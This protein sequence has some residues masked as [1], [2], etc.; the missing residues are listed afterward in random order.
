M[1]K[2][3]YTNALDYYNRAMI[4]SPYYPYLHI[5]MAL[6]KTQ[7]QHPVNEI[8]DHYKK[9]I[10]Y[11]PYYYGGYHY[12]GSW[13]WGQG[14]INE[15]I[16]NLRISI[17]KAP[18]VLYSRSVLM[19]LY[20]S[21][22]LWQE[23]N[24]LALETLSLFPEYAEAKS[25]LAH[26]E[27]QGVIKDE[28]YFINLGLNQYN[29][30]QYEAAISSWEEALKLNPRSAIIHNNIGSAF[31][32]MKEYGKAIPWLEKALEIDPGFIL[33]ANNLKLAKENI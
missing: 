5:N 18:A 14:R 29:S 6:C 25:Y 27:Q 21:Q 30:Q 32:A 10:Q 24:T 26:S 7:M 28:N 2:G 4:Q 3:D 15:A 11:G 1:R 16:D 9:A 12:Y 8:E 13:L 20:F 31:N 22:Q 23:L 19:Q 17:S 33:A